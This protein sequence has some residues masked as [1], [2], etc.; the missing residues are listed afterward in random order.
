MKETELASNLAWERLPTRNLKENVRAG[1][2][3]ESIGEAEQTVANLRERIQ[4]FEQEQPATTGR[5]DSQD[6]DKGNP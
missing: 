1:I 6:N 3:V 2:K 5:N 4:A